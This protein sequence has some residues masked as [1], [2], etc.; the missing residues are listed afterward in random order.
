ML[1]NGDVVLVDT[2]AG[3]E[4][5]GRGVEEGS[6]AVL[7]VADP[8]VESLELAKILKEDVVKM[9]KSF[10]L[11]LNKATPDIADII[12]IKAKDMG[13]ELLGTVRFDREIFKSCLEG[14]TLGAEKAYEDI[15]EI[16][17]KV[18]LL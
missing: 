17:R 11:I 13:L 15:E 16:L 2:D 4:H 6:D 12:R 14:S 10:W 18:I 3:I 7:M 8:T 1:G 9:G 5:L